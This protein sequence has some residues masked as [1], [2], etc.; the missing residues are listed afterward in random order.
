MQKIYN[1]GVGMI[2][3]ENLEKIT[4]KDNYRC[5]LNRSYIPD[6]TVLVETSEYNSI[7]LTHNVMNFLNTNNSKYIDDTR[8]TITGFKR[9]S[10]LI[11]GKNEDLR[12]SFFNGIREFIDLTEE[13]LN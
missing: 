9:N 6:N 3:H 7:F 1:Q 4:K 11:S 2:E 13:G 5:Y 12:K 10:D 8:L